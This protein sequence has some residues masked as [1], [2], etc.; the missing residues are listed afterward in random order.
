MTTEAIAEKIRK[1]LAL[2]SNNPSQAES[3]S[4]LAKAQALMTEHKIE[5][6][7]LDASNSAPEESNIFSSLGAE[8]G[9]SRAQWLSLIHISEPTRPY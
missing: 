7:M 9:V 8:E 6:A 3:A 2:A 4:A 5:Q 1:L